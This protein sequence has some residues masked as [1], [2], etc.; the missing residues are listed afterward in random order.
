MAATNEAFERNQDSRA[1]VGQHGRPK[2]G[3]AEH[4]RHQETAFSPNAMV[5]FCLMLAIMLFDSLGIV[6][7]Y[8][9]L[10][11]RRK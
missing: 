1:G 4:R 10:I 11:P 2:S 7:R 9:L 8:S 6:R 5:M 3:D